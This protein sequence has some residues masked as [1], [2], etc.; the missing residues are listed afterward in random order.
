MKLTFVQKRQVAAFLEENGPNVTQED[1]I[2][3]GKSIN[4]ERESVRSIFRGVEI[5]NKELY[6]NAL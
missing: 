5:V 4:C 6:G 3:F 1:V 2:S